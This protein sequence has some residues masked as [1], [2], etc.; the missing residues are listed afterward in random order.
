MP[1]IEHGESGDK[2]E[3]ER[4]TIRAGRITPTMPREHISNPTLCCYCGEAPHAYCSNNAC[5]HLTCFDCAYETTVTATD[6]DEEI[7]IHLC[8]HCYEPERQTLDSRPNSQAQ[9]YYGPG[10]F[11]HCESCGRYG[12]CTRECLRCRKRWLCEDCVLCSY[13]RQKGIDW[14]LRA[15]IGTGDMA[16]KDKLIKD[17]NCLP[18]KN[19]NELMDTTINNVANGYVR[20]LQDAIELFDRDHAW[21][22]MVPEIFEEPGKINFK[23][24]NCN[25]S[26][27][28]VHSKNPALPK[29]NGKVVLGSRR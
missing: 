22:K 19:K 29:A 18:S 7:T 2:G 15:S 10:P 26:N 24:M 14:E 20:S 12:Q 28:K 4:D 3:Q 8:W 21:W 11:P 16:D 17:S 6:T 9:R 5:L 27:R 25:D 13:C 1:T 23:P